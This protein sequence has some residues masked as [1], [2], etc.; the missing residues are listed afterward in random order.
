MQTTIIHQ[1][2][3]EEEQWGEHDPLGRKTQDEDKI[4]NKLW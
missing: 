2:T 1:N 3:L 4:F